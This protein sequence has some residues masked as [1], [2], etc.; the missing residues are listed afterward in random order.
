MAGGRRRISTLG[1]QWAPGTDPLPQPPS[2]DGRQKPVTDRRVGVSWA[3]RG[4]GHWSVCCLP[5]GVHGNA[6]PILRQASGARAATPPAARAGDVWPCPSG[7][8]SKGGAAMQ[9]CYR[10]VAPKLPAREACAKRVASMR[11]R[12][13]LDAQERAIDPPLTPPFDAAKALRITSC[14]SRAQPGTCH[15]PD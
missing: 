4:S 8:Q 13:A 10:P 14:W 1:S 12:A 7:V 2:T 5:W 9:R 11:R 3:A 6:T 15:S